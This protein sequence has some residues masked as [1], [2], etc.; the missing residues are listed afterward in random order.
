M[1]DGKIKSS[2]ENLILN[3]GQYQSYGYNLS[4]IEGLK[5]IGINALDARENARQRFL[6]FSGQFI[7]Y[8][9]KLKNF[10]K[11]EAIIEKGVAQA[12]INLG[13][14]VNYQKVNFDDVF[15]GDA[16]ITELG[17]ETFTFGNKSFTR[18]QLK[19]LGRTVEENENKALLGEDVP[20][21]DL[22]ASSGWTFKQGETEAIL[23][24]SEDALKLGIVFQDEVQEA[25]GK[26]LWEDNGIQHWSTR[27]EVVSDLF[28]NNEKLKNLKTTDGVLLGTLYEENLERY[29]NELHS[30]TV[31]NKA[32]ENIQTIYKT[33]KNQLSWDEIKNT[34]AKYESENAGGKYAVGMQNKEGAGFDL[35]KYQINTRYLVGGE[36]SFEMNADNQTYA[37]LFKS[38]DTVLTDALVGSKVE[39]PEQ[40]PNYLGNKE[41]L[42]LGDIFGNNSFFNQKNNDTT[43]DYVFEDKNIYNTLFKN[44]LIDENWNIYNLNVIGK[45]GQ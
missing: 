24:S 16:K 30:D 42:D 28:K 8:L 38:I 9:D 15:R 3:Q 44:K 5:T 12:E 17:K 37:T 34:I 19:A 39:A 26:I 22:S 27:Q 20:P 14:P 21:V 33:V 45:K 2:R 25:I 43:I 7:T 35:G 18:A 23:G 4:G 29:N 40:K 31:R 6:D 11:D 36:G 41:G 1:P 32:S 13:V 10:Q